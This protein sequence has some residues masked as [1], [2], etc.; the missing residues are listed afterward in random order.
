MENL[1]DLDEA[2]RRLLNRVR[3][4]SP[5]ECWI[6]S[7]IPTGNGYGAISIGGRMFGAHRLAF[8]VYWGVLLPSWLQVC[9]DC[10]GGDNKLCCNP[11]HLFVSDADG[12]LQDR[13]TKGQL[14]IGNL[15]GSKTRP[16]RVPRGVRNGHAKVNEL[17][18][19]GIMARWLQGIPR[20]QIARE[21]GVS[22]S[23]VREIVTSR[24]WKYLF[25]EESNGNT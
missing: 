4:G 11:A 7:G 17:Q 14:P 2:E 21:F 13:Q 8:E 3:M 19:V 25:E 9:H 1:D 20:L 22:S 12:H 23:L 5:L 24:T 16:E 18:A 6:C 15:N 10:P